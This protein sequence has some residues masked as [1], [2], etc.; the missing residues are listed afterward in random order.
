MMPETLNGDL[1]RRVLISQ[2]DGATQGPNGSYRVILETLANVTPEMA[3]WKPAADR[4]SIWELVEHGRPPAGESRG[5]GRD[6]RRGLARRR[7]RR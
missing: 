3:S 1:L 2:V 5:S 4:H 6:F 7:M